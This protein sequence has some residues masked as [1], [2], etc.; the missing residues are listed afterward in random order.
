MRFAWGSPALHPWL[1]AWIDAIEP[2]PRAG[3]RTIS[4][5]RLTLRCGRN[6]R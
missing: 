6:L 1:D 5:E 2:R 4:A 3:S